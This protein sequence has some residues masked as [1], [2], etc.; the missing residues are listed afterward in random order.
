M[1]S[2]FLP[3][4]KEVDSFVLLLVRKVLLVRKALLAV[5]SKFL[6]LLALWKD[7]KK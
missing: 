2:S 6:A 3:L 5:E 1:S 4:W 7:Q